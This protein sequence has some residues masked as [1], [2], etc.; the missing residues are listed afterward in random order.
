MPGWDRITEL[1]TESL[2]LRNYCLLCMCWE[3]NVFVHLLFYCLIYWQQQTLSLLPQNCLQSF[4]QWH[5]EGKSQY[6]WFQ[7]TGMGSLGLLSQATRQKFLWTLLFCL[8][9]VVIVF[10]ASGSDPIALGLFN[11]S[12][13][14]ECLFIPPSNTCTSL[15]LSFLFCYK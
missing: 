2:C 15:K 1:M 4:L 5:I 12:A 14:L 10:C 8:L 13:Y 7:M 6:S 3:K 9:R 11:C